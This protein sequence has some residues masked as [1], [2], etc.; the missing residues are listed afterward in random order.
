MKRLIV[1]IMQMH[2]QAL[3]CLKRNTAKFATNQPVLDAINELEMRIGQEAALQRAI[4]KRTKG[5]A[6]SKKTGRKTMAEMSDAMRR[7]VQAAAMGNNDTVAFG[8]ANITYSEV[9]YGATLKG[10]ANAQIIHDLANAVSAPDKATYQI[11][12]GDLTGLQDQINLV[13]ALNTGRRSSVV[14]KKTSGELMVNAVTETSKYVHDTIDSLMGNYRVKDGDMYKEYLN[15]RII[16]SPAGRHAE[17]TGTVVQASTNT[18][19]PNVKVTATNGVQVFEDMTDTKGRFKMPVSP[20]L[21]NVK[22]EIATYTPAQVD[23]ILVDAAMHEQVD[24][25]LT[26]VN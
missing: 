8:N 24:V 11:L 25:K 21:Y 3:A 7:R 17:I 26:K 18:P 12:A 4:T 16:V 15:A 6:S 1:T 23:D 2:E 14:T 5:Y 19:I 20:E 13:S 22:F 10:I 9:A